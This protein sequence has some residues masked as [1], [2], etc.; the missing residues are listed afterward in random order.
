MNSDMTRTPI[1]KH[2]GVSFVMTRTIKI[3][4]LEK[5]F[6]DLLTYTTCESQNREDSLIEIGCTP[7]TPPSGMGCAYFVKSCYTHPR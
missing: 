4:D 7:A 6:V 1:G 5:N 3:D 2:G